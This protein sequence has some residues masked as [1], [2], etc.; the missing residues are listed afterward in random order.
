M[1]PWDWQILR[2]IVLEAPPYLVWRSEFDDLCEQQTTQN[3]LSGIHITAH[4]LQGLGQYSAL[5]Q[6]L[7]FDPQGDDQTSLCA[8]RAWEGIPE[9][10]VT[11]C[12]LAI[13]KQG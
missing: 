11:Q 1:S 6:Q 12:S 10:N 4:M 8:K 13:I 2:K 9:N 3:Q 7:S 5:D